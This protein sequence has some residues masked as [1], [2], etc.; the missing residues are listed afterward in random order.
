MYLKLNTLQ[1][2]IQ[3]HMYINVHVNTYVCIETY[4][5]I[6]M[7]MER[8]IFSHYML[9]WHFTYNSL[10]LLMI[11]RIPYSIP[12][13]RISCTYFIWARFNLCEFSEPHSLPWPSKNEWD[14][15]WSEEHNVRL[16]AG[17]RW[18]RG[19][20]LGWEDWK[21]TQCSWIWGHGNQG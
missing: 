11:R 21:S 18:Q 17:Y 15:R 10:D 3:T 8:F 14:T 4:V 16:K 5:C 7:Y 19:E 12:N 13:I 20:F 9:T 1:N 6:C 2:H